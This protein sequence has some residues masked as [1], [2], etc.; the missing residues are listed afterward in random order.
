MKGALLLIN[1]RQQVQTGSA[2][3]TLGWTINLP[4]YFK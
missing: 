3:G 2:T 1:P 4:K